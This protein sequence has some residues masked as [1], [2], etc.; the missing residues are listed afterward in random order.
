[1]STQDTKERILDAATQLFVKNG[2][3]RTT[4][5]VIAEK[6]GVAESTFFRIYKSKQIL[7]EDLLFVMSAGP[8]NLDMSI[9][10]GGKNP[11]KDFEV[12]L[13]GTALQHIKHI[14]VFR[15]AMHLETIYT[16]Q[17]LS[18]IKT[19]VALMGDYFNEL[20]Q[21]G[22]LLEFDFHALSEHINAL[23]LTKSSEFI[24]AENEG[25]PAEQSARR[26]ALQY[27]EY[28]SRL[29]VAGPKDNGNSPSLSATPKNQIR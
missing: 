27:A 5:R 23:V 2:F 8:E 21:K 11:R 3:A 14:P 26:F 20:G 6:A 16:Q 19:V 22:I 17:R 7:L 10:T 24:A 15:L 13:Y 1:M 18:R 4:T 28:F 9:L 29:F 12:L 25:I